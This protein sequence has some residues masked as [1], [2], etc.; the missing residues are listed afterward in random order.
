MNPIVKHCST[1][2]IASMLAR[3]EKK[4]LRAII[5][6]ERH[7]FDCWEISET[8]GKSRFRLSLALVIGAYE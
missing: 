8:N 1:S 6:T 5:A 7:P 3:A 4:F 2:T